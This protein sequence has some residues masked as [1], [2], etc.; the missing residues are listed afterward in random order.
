MGRFLDYSRG[1]DKP[2]KVHRIE[3]N[4]RHLQHNERPHG[5]PAKKSTSAVAGVLIVLALQQKLYREMT[6][7][8][9]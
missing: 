3:R 5:S 8:E 2:L 7:G 1:L 6:L 4:T 9:Y